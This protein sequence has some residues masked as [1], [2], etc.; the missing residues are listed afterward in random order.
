[1]STPTLFDR[2]AEALEQ[3]TSLSRLEA[4]GTLRL[5]AQRLGLDPK[6]LPAKDLSML[7]DV[8]L[9]RELASRGFHDGRE[10]CRKIFHDLQ[11]PPAAPGP[12][13]GAP[14]SLFD[15]TANAVE[16]RT[17]L[18]RLEARG[19]LRHILKDAGLPVDRTTRKQMEVVLTA[20]AP[21][22]LQTTG[23]AQAEAV[24]Q[25]ILEDLKTAVVD[26]SHDADSPE[27]VFDRLGR[28]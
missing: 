28:R 12:S 21:K 19:T 17:T 27:E 6:D 4:R 16:T 11:A 2:I 7:L 22:H 23:V 13:T 8:A 9:P 20:L 3:G 26:E 18:S 5:T 10:L 25:A 1:M 24:C 15:W 14:P